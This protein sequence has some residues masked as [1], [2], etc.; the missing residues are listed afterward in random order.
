[1]KELLRIIES[2]R[3]CSYLPW[4]TATLEIRAVM[5]MSSDEYGILLSGGWRRFGWQVFRP[6]LPP[7]T[8]A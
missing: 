3:P 4:E 2:P 7:A 1:M 6:C 5:S 8:S